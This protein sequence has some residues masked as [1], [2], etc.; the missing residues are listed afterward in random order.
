MHI[1]CTG[2]LSCA[3]FISVPCFP[4][5]SPDQ[6]TTPHT[7]NTNTTDRCHPRRLGGEGRLRLG[8]YRLRQDRRLLPPHFGAPP[9][10]PQERGG[11]AYV[12]CSLSYPLHLLNLV[13]MDMDTVTVW[14][15]GYTQSPSHPQHQHQP[16]LP[17]QKPTTPPK[18]ASLLSPRRGS[19]PYR[20]T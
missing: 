17:H 2:G 1:K 19:W 8:R 18:Q 13:Y 5:H 20:R 3:H 9:L 11:H 12:R 15:C 4:P 16:Q 6:P 7:T 14:V 10:P